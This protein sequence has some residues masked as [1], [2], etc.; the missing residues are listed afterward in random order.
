M[1][2]K[3]ALKADVID[4]FVRWVMAGMPQSAVDAAALSTTP[5]PAP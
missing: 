5:T 4:V 2:P 3:K 1:P